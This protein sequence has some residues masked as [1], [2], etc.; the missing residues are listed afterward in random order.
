MVPRK[1][2]KKI[3]N[4]N[5]RNNKP[6]K[7]YSESIPTTDRVV[8]V[9]TKTSRRIHFS[10]GTYLYISTHAI[11]IFFFFF[12][13]ITI[14]PFLKRY[15]SDTHTKSFVRIVNAS[16]FGLV[17]FVCRFQGCSHVIYRQSSP[18]LVPPPALPVTAFL[19]RFGGLWPRARTYSYE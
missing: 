16:H 18:K 12:L 7:N 17:N 3:Y 14:Y 5:N 6:E 15:T 1:T 10:I 19:L 4:N 13:N 11:R 8:V 9:F 2:R